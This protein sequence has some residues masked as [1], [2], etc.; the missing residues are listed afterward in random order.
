[1]P[2]PPAA[3]EPHRGEHHRAD[4]D[5]EDQIDEINV[6]FGGSVS[7]ASKTQDKNLER[8]FSL[9]QRIETKRIMKWSDTNI[10]F[11]PHDHTE[12]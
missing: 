1:M 11:R 2:P 8:K 7:I 12:T 6:I 4:P 5:N 3:L 9:A 10:S